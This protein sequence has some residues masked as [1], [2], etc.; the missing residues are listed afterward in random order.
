MPKILVIDDDE[1]LRE[2][3]NIYLTQANEGY[4]VV[5]A[6]NGKTGIQK[7][8]DENPDIVISD[9]KMP[10]INGIEV[11]EF[12]KGNY[13][14]TQI[15]MITAFDDVNSTIEA[16]QKG[17][18]DYVNKPLDI[19][20]IKRKIKKALEVRETADKSDT[21]HIKGGDSL[22]DQKLVGKT[23]VMREIYKY[24]GQ[25]SVNKVTVLLEG[26]SGT[27]KELIAKIIHESGSHDEPFIAVNCSAISAHLLESEL[28]GHVKGAFTDAWRDKRGKFELAGEGTIFLDEISEMS[29]NLQSKLLRVLQEK[30][31]EKVGGEESLPMEARII[32]ATNKN[33][34][35]LVDE[36]KFREDLYYRLNVFT[37]RMP[38]LSERKEDIPLLVNYFIQKIN[39]ELGKNIKKIPYEVMEYLQSREWKGNIRELENTLRQAAVLCKTEVLEKNNIIISSETPRPDG[40]PIKTLR[41]LEE[42]EKEHINFVLS[43]VNWSIKK[44]CEVLQISKPTLYRK[45]ESYQLSKNDSF[46]S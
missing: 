7:I 21:Y 9:I 44:A 11:L 20:Q 5:T 6:N 46:D 31:F 1:T 2:S 18:Y 37:I 27:G 22:I 41:S 33:L 43:E 13:P 35:Q 17:A 29:L 19:P 8:K 3:L 24:I 10:D 40:K 36:G 14:D 4:T 39:T 12:V 16:M 34:K 25:L 23:P 38:S 28:F 15:I 45:I 30:S 42:V 32:A 26:D